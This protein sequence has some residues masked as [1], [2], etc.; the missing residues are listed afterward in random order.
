MKA[1]RVVAIALPKMTDTALLAI[2]D[3]VMSNEKEKHA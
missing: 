3:R 1:E 2:L